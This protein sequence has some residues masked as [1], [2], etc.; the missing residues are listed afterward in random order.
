MTKELTLSELLKITSLGHNAA[1]I[2]QFHVLRQQAFE[3]A[4]KV[5]A[6]REQSY[7]VDHE[8]TEEMAFGPISLAGELYKRAKRMCGLLSPIR[9]KPLRPE[10]L[11]RMVDLSIDIINYSSWF[12]ALILQAIEAGNKMCDDAP[13]YA[14][15]PFNAKFDVPVITITGV[16][17]ISHE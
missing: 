17:S 10:D 6:D 4:R 3:T 11:N 12:Y 13:M 2:E 16:E 14:H 8:P 9:S 7:N 15:I 5:Y 1:Q